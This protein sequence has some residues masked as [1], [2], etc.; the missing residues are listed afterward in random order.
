MYYIKTF[1]AAP[2]GTCQCQI[3]HTIALL[4]LYLTHFH[5]CTPTSYT[6]KAPEQQQQALNSIHHQI[7]AFDVS[8]RFGI[9]FA[10]YIDGSLR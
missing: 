7:F 9:H 10:A 1:D 5:T 4:M 2:T 3:S 8:L 6:T